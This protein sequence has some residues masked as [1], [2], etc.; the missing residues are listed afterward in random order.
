MA[1]RPPPP[2]CAHI[3]VPWLNDVEMELRA[4]LTASCIRLE[5]AI[6][7][8]SAHGGN[9]DATAQVVLSSGRCVS[10]AGAQ[11]LLATWRQEAEMCIPLGLLTAVLRVAALF[12]SAIDSPGVRHVAVANECAHILT[13]EEELGTPPEEPVSPFIVADVYTTLL[14]AFEL[15]A[16]DPGVLPSNAPGSVVVST[17]PGSR[18][19]FVHHQE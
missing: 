16:C 12:Q 10:M 18:P 5:Q 9:D 3:F 19:R 8:A 11:S 17:C 14:D 4:P 13:A 2:P 1:C 15:L 6:E 7:A